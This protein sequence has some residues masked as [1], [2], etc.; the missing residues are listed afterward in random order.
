LRNGVIEE[1]PGLYEFVKSTAPELKYHNDAGWNGGYYDVS[2]GDC[3]SD[4]KLTQLL[5]STE[6]LQKEELQ[7]IVSGWVSRI[8]NYVNTVVKMCK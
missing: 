4:D 7:K 6:E 8:G 2:E 3:L 5:E 1:V